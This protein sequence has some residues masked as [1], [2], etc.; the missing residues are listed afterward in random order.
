MR[1]VI[2][3]VLIGLGVA[4][5]VAAP[6]L[7]WYAAPRLLKAPLDQFS[8]TVSEASDVTYLDIAALEVKTGPRVRRHPH[9]P[10]RRG[11][12][13]R[14]PRGLRRL[15]QDHRPGEGRRGRGAARQRQHRPRRLRPL[16]VRGDELLRRE[17]QRRAHQARGHRV[18]VPVRHREED[19]P[20]LRH[21]DRGR[22]RHG[23]RAGVRARGPD[24]LRV[25]AGHR[26]DQDRRARR[27]G[28]PGGPRRGEPDRRP[29]LLQRPPRVGR[30]AS[31]GS[32][33]RAPRASCR[34]CAT[35][36]RTC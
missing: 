36:A 31:P 23:V 6:L 32:S 8:E 22:H 19:L 13:R 1:R 27:A 2:G 9:R 24:G 7:K 4:A 29:V 12:R 20:V 16:D 33:S 25:R 21:L 14:R 5:L 28:R 35:A 18:Q 10:R 30:A 26:A 15:R 17:P 11:R 34:R 3:L